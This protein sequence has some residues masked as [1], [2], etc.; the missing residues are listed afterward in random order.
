MPSFSLRFCLKCQSKC[1]LYCAFA[2]RGKRW[3]QEEHCTPWNN[4]LIAPSWRLKIEYG[5]IY[6]ETRGKFHINSNFSKRSIQLERLSNS[7][8]SL[9]NCLCKVRYRSWDNARHKWSYYV[10]KMLF[11][12]WLKQKAHLK[13]L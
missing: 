3:P 13:K 1:S 9:V 6:R 5:H 7:V 4:W 10:R 11:V 8:N 2:L 12:T